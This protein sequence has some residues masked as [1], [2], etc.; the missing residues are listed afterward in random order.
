MRRWSPLFGALVLVVMLA[1]SGTAASDEVNGCSGQATEITDCH[2]EFTLETD[3]L[4]YGIEVGVSTSQPY[5][6]AHMDGAIKSETGRYILSCRTTPTGYC[7]V[8]DLEGE[9][10][11]G[12]TVTVEA[13]GVTASGRWRFWA[14]PYEG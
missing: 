2:V 9:F 8:G 6:I 7:H 5:F 13:W 3:S 12:Q 14:E 1:G 4:L 11:R 10:I